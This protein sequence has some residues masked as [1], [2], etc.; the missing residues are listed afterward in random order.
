MSDRFRQ[1]C[2][3]FFFLTGIFL[4]LASRAE[5]GLLLVLVGLFAA[6]HF[7]I[8]K[9]IRKNRIE[10]QGQDETKHRSVFEKNNTAY[11]EIVKQYVATSGTILGLVVA[12][13]SKEFTL[14]LLVGCLSLAV[15]IAIGLVLLEM[16]TGDSTS[17]A[18]A[19]LVSWIYHLQTWA[20]FLGIL[21]L[22]FHVWDDYLV[23][24]LG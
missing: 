4:C 18:G 13:H 7:A 19:F 3:A 17:H 10:Y 8:T 1:I 11:R 2:A 5:I 23:A 9:F 21:A 24:K 22:V 15:S 12:L 14:L 16:L 6:S 20:L